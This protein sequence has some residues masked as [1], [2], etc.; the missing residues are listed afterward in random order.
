MSVVGVASGRD[1]EYSRLL[2]NAGESV[3]LGSA[4]VVLADPDRIA[5]L[6]L[7]EVRWV[8]STWAG[9]DAVDWDSVPEEVVITTLPGVF[10]P[11]IAE[12]VF[13]HL[14]ARTQRIPQRYAT[15]HWD[16]TVPEMLGGTTIGILGAGSIG[17]SIA[18]VAV[19][20]GMFVHGCRRSGN[21]D[22]RFDSMYEM[23]DV[24]GFASGLDHLVAVLPATD[25]TR[26]LIDAD[27][28]RRLAPGASF[29]NV[30]RGSTA[31]TDDIVACVRDG[32]IGLAV[33]DVTDPEPL[34]PTHAAW[35]TPGVVITGHTAAHSR[36]LDIVEFFV[37]NLA[38]FRA[39]RPLRGVVDRER[40]Y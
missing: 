6:D 32:A 39:G 25:E 35:D 12:F 13:G 15:R 26:G 37:A 3:I 40:G 33:L 21:S 28:L 11:Q 2:E 38:R 1:D 24:A 29:I 17:A 7:G 34:P 9:V 23:Y 36:P 16:E 8:Q 4:E 14:L 19:S 27:L 20:L 22:H 10:G 5:T 18:E 31:V 30:G